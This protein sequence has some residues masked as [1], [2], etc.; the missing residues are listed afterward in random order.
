MIPNGHNC[1][2]VPNGTNCQIGDK[3]QKVTIVVLPE[4]IVNPGTVV[5][6]REYAK[7]AHL[8]VRRTRRFNLLTHPAGPFPNLFEI[9]RSLM[10]VFHD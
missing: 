4:A 6:H 3:E 8:A 10:P 2:R 5:I 7:I 9:I 1:E